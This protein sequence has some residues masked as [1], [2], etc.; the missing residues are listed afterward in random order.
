MVFVRVFCFTVYSNSVVAPY[1]VG[2]LLAVFILFSV[3][4][5]NPIKTVFNAITVFTFTSNISLSPVTFIADH[6]SRFTS[7]C[8]RVLFFLY[9]DLLV[10]RQIFG[11]GMLSVTLG[12]IACWVFTKVIRCSLIWHESVSLKHN[13]MITAV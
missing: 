11:Y 2:F 7:G 5:A 13:Y 1:H 4:D 3:I 6:L 12:L 9:N 10:V 8:E